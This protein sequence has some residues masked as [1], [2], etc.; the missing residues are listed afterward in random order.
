MANQDKWNPHTNKEVAKQTF[1]DLTGS[2]KQELYDLYVK[3]KSTRSIVADANRTTKKFVSPNEVLDK[4]KWPK[5]YDVY[6]VDASPTGDI[7]DLIVEAYSKGKADGAYK[8]KKPRGKSGYNIF[9]SS[10]KGSG[11][12]FKEIAGE[13]NKLSIDEKDEWKRKAK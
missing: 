2:E 6:G 1:D 5:K 13:W 3:G 10:Q 4:K 7:L 12:S 8:S 11:N 9:V